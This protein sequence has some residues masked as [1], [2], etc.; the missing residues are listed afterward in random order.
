[1]IWFLMKAFLLALA[2]LPVTLLGLLLVAACS[3]QPIS[4]PCPSMPP[5]P[6]ALMLPPQNAY[7]LNNSFQAAPRTP[8]K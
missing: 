8:E 6:K 4:A 1:M 5:V 2:G 7:L 3:H